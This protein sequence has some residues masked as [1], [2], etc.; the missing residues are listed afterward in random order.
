[1]RPRALIV[2]A[3]IGGL[4]AAIAL[5]RKGLEVALF[6]RAEALEEIGAGL[7]AT[8]NATRVLAR[9]GVL[10]T[11]EA[12]ALAPR[13]IRII[14]GRDG[15]ELA[16]LQLNATARWGAPYL[17]LHRADL[18]R[19][20]L[21]CAA[22]EKSVA[23]ALGAEV[24]G[25]K[26]DAM[27]VTLGLRRGS[28]RLAESGD[29]L[30]G[31]DGLRSIV[32]ER[33]GLGARGEARFSG[34][35]AFRAAVEASI[36]P[37]RACEP[38]ISLELGARAHLVHY[39]LRGGALVNIVAVIESDWR[40]APED[41]PWDGEADQAALFAAFASWSKEARRLIEAARGWRAWPLYDRAPL[42]TMAV[43]RVALIGDAAHPMLPFLA[44]GAAQAIEDAGALAEC[45]AAA[46]EIPAALAAYS[47]RRLARVVRVQ[48]AAADQARLYHLAGAAA[49][50]RDLGMRALGPERLLQ[51]YDWIYRE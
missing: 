25:F 3:G 19:A 48:Q 15:A 16:R 28:I 2:G 46:S 4:T 17:V 43:G 12:H 30:I 26:E 13:A 11:V 21:E 31:A 45:L 40:G 50:I 35:V 22:R 7:Q 39:P 5:A 27:G 49:L 37:A 47:K 33:L 32:R 9:L 20:L 14:R 29:L 6:E 38:D 8:P 10:Q 23:L 51:R 18:Q 1:M 24:A 41:D 34:R 42:T 44:Q 36:A